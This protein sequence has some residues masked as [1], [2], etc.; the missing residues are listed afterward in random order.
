MILNVSKKWLDKCHNC[1]NLKTT[2]QDGQITYRACN[3]SECIYCAPNVKNHTCGDCKYWRIYDELR[4][5]GNCP[6]GE[7]VAREFVGCEAFNPREDSY[8]DN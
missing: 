8:D 4:L 6:R 2:K 1:E 3:A 5:L 7:D